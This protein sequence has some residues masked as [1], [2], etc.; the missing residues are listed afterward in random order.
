[1]FIVLLGPPGAGKGTQA[2]RLAGQL[3]LAHIATGNLL[4]EAVQHGTPIG[5][6]AQSYLDRGELVPDEVMARLVAERLDAP[7][8]RAG[9]IFDGYPRTLVQAVEFDR[10]L[11]RRRTRL[12]LAISVDIAADV[13]VRR[14]SS[15]R[16]CERCGA[17]YNLI[18]N[19]P[20][21]AGL[22][23]RCGEPLVGRSDDSPAVIRRRLDIYRAEAGPLEDYYAEGDR[24]AIVAGDN[25]PDVVTATIRSVLRGVRVPAPMPA[26][27]LSA[28]LPAG[29]PRQSSGGW[30]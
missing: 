9:A 23:D 21:Q 30:D 24:L 19:P 6:M 2:A 20:I 10:E 7:D 4:R 1:M 25:P 3:N 16:V 18:S 26:V 12:T 27:G 29:A 8:A 17:T 28:T 14:L 22:C 5:L 15:R 11:A 13:L